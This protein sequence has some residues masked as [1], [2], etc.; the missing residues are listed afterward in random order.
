M[1]KLLLV[2][3]ALILITG[4]GFA[5]DEQPAAGAAAEPRFERFNMEF[6][7]GFP[8]HW[9]NG[10]DD[11]ELY[12]WN[13]PTDN[14]LNNRRP[15]KTVTASTSFGV[16]FVT[17]FNRTFGVTVDAD[18]F[19]GTRLQGFATPT[20]DYVSMFGFN[21]FLGPI[22]NIFN[23]DLLK[24]PL[25]IGGHLYYFSDE[26]W[27]PILGVTSGTPPASAGEWL[28]RKDLQFGPAVSLGVQFHFDRTIYL[29][30]RTMVAL[31]LYRIITL[32]GFNDLDNDSV[33]EYS[34]ITG[35]GVE[36][37]WLVKPSIGLGIKW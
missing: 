24:V 14:G 37:N 30:S 8:I 29:F 7:M 9:S 36:M 31:D 3:C 20:S 25:G 2:F 17:N 4:L 34:K 19:Y 18:I 32:E 26:V 13:N 5:Q 10:F 22:I 23:N 16:A 28:K 15:D 21:A 27:A 6:S 1:R 33:P 12:W 11:G 35:R